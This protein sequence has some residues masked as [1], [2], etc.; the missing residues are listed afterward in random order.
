MCIFYSFNLIIEKFYSLFGQKL[1]MVLVFLIKIG[2]ANKLLS[3][4][5]ELFR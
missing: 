3:I 1:K 5:Q 4:L 2:K